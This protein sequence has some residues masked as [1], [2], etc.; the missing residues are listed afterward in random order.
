M[1]F[2]I[3]LVAMVIGGL[4]I[5]TWVTVHKAATAALEYYERQNHAS[6]IE[7]RPSSSILSRS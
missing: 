5:W 2:V 6:R 4:G 7:R 3:F 1:E